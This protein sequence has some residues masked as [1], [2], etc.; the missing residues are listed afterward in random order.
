MKAKAFKQQQEKS[1]K[2]LYK[3]VEAKKMEVVKTKLEFTKGAVKN[4]KEPKRKY[5]VKL[6]KTASRDMP[7]CWKFTNQISLIRRL[8]LSSPKHTMI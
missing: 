1:I 4:V 8:P 3:D 6:S 7:T 2:E 5:C